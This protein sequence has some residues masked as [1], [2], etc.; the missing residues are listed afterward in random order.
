M[1]RVCP[2]L[3][4]LFSVASRFTWST[5]A[6]VRERE[7]HGPSRLRFPSRWE[8]LR[9]S[10]QAFEALMS[11]KDGRPSEPA[12]EP[13]RRSM[14]AASEGRRA[15]PRKGTGVQWLASPGR[16]PSGLCVTALVL[17]ILTGC[18][19]A[20]TSAGATTTTAE[21]TAS[22]PAIAN[23]SALDET[24]QCVVTVLRHLQINYA[25]MANN[26]EKN[27][28]Q[29][30]G[31]WQ[32]QGGAKTPEWFIFGAHN[33]AASLSVAF[34]S[35]SP[36]DQLLHEAPAVA[37]EC[38]RAHNGTF[39]SGMAGLTAAG[40]TTTTSA[41]PSLQA[42][43]VPTQKGAPAAPPPDSHAA[44]SERVT[45][46]LPPLPKYWL[47]GMDVSSPLMTSCLQAMLDAVPRIAAGQ[48][49]AV[50][51]DYGTTPN[52]LYWLEKVAEP[53]PKGSLQ[54]ALAWMNAPDPSGLTDGEKEGVGQACV[55]WA[56]P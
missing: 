37:A 3:R 46:K 5:Y 7:P 48:D 53:A 27:T 21:P 50:R 36:A 11:V 13:R 43:A 23:T 6:D 17:L 12:T 22:A 2:P 55:A 29:D 42:P 51:A 10:R 39:E 45:R 31:A 1:K 19:S 33:H 41:Q 4:A 28:L 14:A 34:G 38:V 20:N 24:G 15:L 25:D 54:G 26:T 9:I 44:G 56:T 52:L 8:R 16:V 47:E 32:A 30:V 49:A 40:L 18:S 35:R